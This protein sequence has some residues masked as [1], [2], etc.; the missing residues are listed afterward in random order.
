MGVFSSAVFAGPAKIALVVVAV[1]GL[2]AGAYFAYQTTQ[3]DADTVSG[4][5]EPTVTASPTATQTTPTP[6]AEPTIAPPTPSPSATTVPTLPP[7]A[8]QPPAPTV[9]P[10]CAARDYNHLNIERLRAEPGLEE[11][12][13]SEINAYNV[14]IEIE[15]IE[16]IITGWG[17]DMGI[18]GWGQPSDELMSI[19]QRAVD[20]LTFVC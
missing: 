18:G 5:T 20:E 11:A 10:A 19:V 3:S 9:D 15:G 1:G 7:P 8:T 4:Q 16:F 2:T 6:T 14:R 17:E 13:I 12:A